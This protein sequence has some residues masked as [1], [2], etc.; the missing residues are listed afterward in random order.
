MDI[1]IN[2]VMGFIIG[3]ILGIV[4]YLCSNKKYD[5]PN[6]KDMVGLIFKDD[7]GCFKLKPMVHICP[8]SKSMNKS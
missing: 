4:Y 8:I 2:L 1:L 5:G 7:Q 6:S 3:I